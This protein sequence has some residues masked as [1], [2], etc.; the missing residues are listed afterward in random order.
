MAAWFTFSMVSCIVLSALLAFAFALK[1][2]KS[3]ASAKD[4]SQYDIQ[5]DVFHVATVLAVLAAGIF[6][7][8]FGCVTVCVQFLEVIK[9]AIEK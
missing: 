6:S 3:K 4:S 9:V 5:G 7:I 8:I 1:A 2:V